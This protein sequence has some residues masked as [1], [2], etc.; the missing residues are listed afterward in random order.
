MGHDVATDNKVAE[1][2]LALHRRMEHTRAPQL[3]QQDLHR[4]IKLAKM[5]NPPKIT[6]A[7]RQ[8]LIRCYKK[9]RE[10]R[11]Y[12]R[13]SAGVTVRQLES[14]IRLSE[15]VARVHLGNEVTVDYVKEAF[16]LQVDTLKRAEKE[17]IDL[18]PEVGDDEIVNQQV[19]T[20]GGSQ[21]G[22][23]MP[24]KVKITYQEYQRFGQMLATRLAQ[25][26]DRGR[27]VTEENL[28]TWFVE[29]REDDIHTEAELEEQ[30]H[31]VQLIINRLIE[32]DRVI[33]VARQSDDYRKP[34][35]RVLVKHPNF[36]VGELITGS[37]RT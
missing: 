24:R 19:E 13:G 26:G 4:Y 7:A 14:L 3:S 17:N 27:E 32:K 30:Q 21:K 10:D 34:E 35:Q 31:L 25:E 1:H 5:M 23:A 29:K 9:L 12:V 8:Q 2:I 6:A 37:S 11:T 18:N 15:A 16:R 33:I 20:D 22:I 36:P 28:I